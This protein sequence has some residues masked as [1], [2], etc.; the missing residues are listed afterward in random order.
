MPNETIITDST[1]YFPENLLREYDIH[2][3]PLKVIWGDKSLDDNIDITSAE[4]YERLALSEVLPTTSLVT[5]AEFK[6]LFAKLYTEGKQILA[7]LLSSGLSGTLASAEQAKA[8]LLEAQIELV[9]SKST[10]VAL[11]FQV[12]VG[13]RAAIN[14]VPLLTCMAAVG[15]ARDKSGVVFLQ[16]S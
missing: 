9:D 8:D 13:T 11:A 15:E 16:H 4:F 10:I 7:I 2:V 1:A 12:L 14:G 3:L 5:V 6:G